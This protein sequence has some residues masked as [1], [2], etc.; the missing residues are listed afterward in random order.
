M[1]QED[2]G[3]LRECLLAVLG[4][5]RSGQ[6]FLPLDNDTL[7]QAPASA[8]KVLVVR[9]SPAED[10]EESISHLVLARE[11][12]TVL[13]PVLVDLAFMPGR[14]DRRVLAGAG[15]PPFVGCRSFLPPGAF[16]LIMVSCS[17][18]PE[19]ANLS[20]LLESA[21][22]PLRALDRAGDDWPL[23][24]LGGAAAL[25]SQAALGLVDAL[26]T[27][28]FE[29][30]SRDL[31]R[32]LQAPA[33]SPMPEPGPQRAAV[34]QAWREGLRQQPG[35][36]WLDSA[37]II[38]GSG[39]ARPEA[40]PGAFAPGGPGLPVLNNPH[41]GT[42]RLLIS[43]GCPFR[44]SFCFEGAVR[45]PYGELDLSSLAGGAA[46]LRRQTGAHSVDLLSFNFNTHRSIMP[47]MAELLAI[48]PFVHL[49]S[50]RLDILYRNP[51]L[52]QAQL[53]CGKRSFTLGIE[54]VSARMRRFFR[55]D[56]AEDSVRGIVGQLLQAGA[57]EIKC[58]Y[59]ISG[60]E[61]EADL[62]EFQ[63]FVRH[64]QAER[65]R[66]GNKAT[67]LYS[68]GYLAVMPHT[69]LSR[70]P[71]RLDPAA[72]RAVH[73]RVQAIAAA[74]GAECR[75]A[76][77]EASW[78]T[79]QVLSL[80]GQSLA[81]E[82][83][84]SLHRQGLRFDDTLDPAALALVRRQL[85][86][87][88]QAAGSWQPEA[89]HPLEGFCPP[90]VL[91]N[92]DAGWAAVQ[93]E[94]AGTYPPA[95]QPGSQPG[96][97]AD[98]RR[99]AGASVPE[100]D[101]PAGRSARLA[102]DARALET[103][104]GLEVRR[105]QLPHLLVRLCL[106]RGLAG[107]C[108]EW[109]EAWVSRR[110]L[111]LPDGEALLRASDVWQESRDRAGLIPWWWGHNIYDLTLREGSDPAAWAAGLATGLADLEPWCLPGF[112]PQDLK[113]LVC[114]LD[115]PLTLWTGQPDTVRERQLQAGLQ[116][117]LA[118]HHV[119]ATLQRLPG[120]FRYA[121]APKAARKAL[122]RELTVWTRAEG[123]QLAL[124]GQPRLDVRDFLKQAV[125]GLLDGFV[126]VETRLELADNP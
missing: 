59:I 110:I 122:V 57:R 53:L 54:G 87:G 42:V 117:A 46:R 65:Q 104:R 95:S 43:L 119:P 101:R 120:G 100:P 71:V 62:D 50:Q 2:P 10:V 13:G 66:L 77:D 68:F 14:Q 84:H 16:D 69:P 26:Y 98:N 114:R 124:A 74:E 51:E 5:L 115:L 23:V 125:P 44:C 75:L 88:A 28:E 61:T 116:R 83:L 29:L 49:M 90:Q 21:G 105:R 31:A 103:I 112:A 20:F 79:G 111:A 85:P 47:L 60:H 4:R 109:G 73:A 64:C 96:S 107:A 121:V 106:P 6:N 39:V 33:S 24:L 15:L 94:L 34:R 126:P 58:F 99:P 55:K 18:V 27:A 7:P 123:W 36:A 38:R 22:L 102:A 35:M 86:A 118:A 81:A 113:G 108:K 89:V 40:V 91:A 1:K 9:L 25:M 52:L 3:H 12:V 8:L 45:K 78:L 17:Y 37:G 76:F 63:A 82:L 92:R 72:F 32:V 56:L 93:P 19:L 67:L 30:V 41:A 97:Q 48:Y 70:L 80:A 11:L